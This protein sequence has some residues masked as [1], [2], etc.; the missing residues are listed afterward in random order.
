M[1]VEDDIQEN[2]SLDEVNLERIEAV[3]D[4]IDDKRRLENK[5]ERRPSVYVNIFEGMSVPVK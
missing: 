3:L 5:E 1:D 2:D 4:D